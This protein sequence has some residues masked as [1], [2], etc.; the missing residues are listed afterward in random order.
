MTEMHLIESLI[1]T[2]MIIHTGFNMRGIYF[3]EFNI[4][5][6]NVLMH[7][8]IKLNIVSNSADNCFLIHYSNSIELNFS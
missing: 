6:L 8:S 7:K 3:I 1:C 5:N 4:G 2:V